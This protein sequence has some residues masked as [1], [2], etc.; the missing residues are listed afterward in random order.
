MKTIFRWGGLLMSIFLLAGV[1]LAQDDTQAD[2]TGQF[3]IPIPAGWTAD[4]TDAWLHYVSPD[5]EANLY[6]FTVEA[7]D[8]NAGIAAA[9]TQ[10]DPAL[11]AEPT[12]S[13]EVPLPNGSSWVQNVYILPENELVVGLGRQEEGTTYV[14]VV[15]GL[16]ASLQA[17]NPTILE[18]LFGYTLSGETARP[19]L[20]EYVNPDAYTEQAI[21]VGAEDWPLEGTLTLPVGDG[22]FPAV[23][24]VHGSGPND[25]DGSIVGNKV[26][27]DLALGLASQGIATLRYDKRTFAYQREF[28]TNPPESF[29]IEAET[30]D[31]ALAAVEA[32]RAVEQI[33]PAR[34]FVMGHS[35]GG[36]FAPAIATRDP[37]LAGVV[38]LAGSARDFDVILR[39]QAEYIHSIDAQTEVDGFIALADQI[40]QLREGATG[41]EAFPDEPMQVV[42]WGSFLAHDVLAEAAA[43]EQPMLILQGE[44]D[45]Q[46]TLEDLALWQGA[47]EG[48]DNVTVITYPTL[49]HT[50]MALG[51]LERLAIPADYAEAGFVDEAVINDIAAWIKGI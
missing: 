13:S 18:T 2:P 7:E 47:L 5:G 26:Y 23:V 12:Q 16:V 14:L 11:T 6:A 31:D 49:M 4:H 40:Q 10:I 28:R 41:E 27:R 32:L 51:D 46:V 8:V 33:D 21:T 22:P 43:L 42:Y 1:A 20:P 24:I 48:R 19:S 25:R 36:T 3:T 15:R 50:F 45:Y 9:L 37:E 29:T 39:A 30:I 34:I 38:M 17:I 44:R 35:Q